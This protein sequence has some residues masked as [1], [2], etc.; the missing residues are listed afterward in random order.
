[1]NPKRFV[2]VVVLALF[3]TAAVILWP[4]A[5][6]A[7]AI[8]Q[9]ELAKQAGVY[10]SPEDGMRNMIEGHYRG[11]ERIVI[12]HAGPNSTQRQ[13]HVWF[14]SARVYAVVRADGKRIAAG[15]YD[16]PGSYFLH[17]DDG[18]VHIPEGAFPE[19]IGSTIERFELYG[20]DQTEG[21]CS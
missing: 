11:I 15:D 7:Y 2:W 10:A 16:Y 8:E 17:V 9:V 21:N 14:V 6:R 1:M 13:P 4:L 18:W 3:I 5:L 20:C 12:D 19:L